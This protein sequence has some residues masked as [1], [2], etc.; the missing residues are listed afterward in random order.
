[1]RWVLIPVILL[2]GCAPRQM[3]V[4]RAPEVRVESWEQLGVASLNARIA[5]GQTNA[6]RWVRSPL[7]M[8]VE[9]FGADTDKRALWLSEEANR[10]EAPDTVV[11]IMVRDGLVDDSVRGDWHRVV[12]RRQGDGSWRVHD[13]RRAYRC[14]RGHHLEAFGSKSCP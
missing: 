14:W 2:A 13:L 6:A 10:G 5:A 12:Y 1:M 9:L 7:R 3:P 11:V 4:I 8:T